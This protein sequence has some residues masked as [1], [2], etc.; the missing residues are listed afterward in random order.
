MHSPGSR[1]ESILMQFTSMSGRTS[2]QDFILIILPKTHLSN[3]YEKTRRRQGDSR[4][5]TFNNAVR[6]LF[7]LR[8]DEAFE[9]L[10]SRQ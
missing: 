7:A 6:I 2:T 8:G 5:R 3:F 10:A 1:R 9:A 4:A